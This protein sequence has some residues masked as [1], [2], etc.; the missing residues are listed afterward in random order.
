MAR[1]RRPIDKG[2]L[3]ASMALALG[4]FLVVFALNSATTGRAALG[5]PE[6]I[7]A[8]SPAKN[9]EVLRQTAVVADLAPGYEGKLIIDR[10]EIEVQTV[11]AETNV[12]PNQQVNQDILVTKFDPGSGTL[13]FQPQEGAP[14]EAFATGTHEVKVI[15]WRLADPTQT[16]SYTWQFKVTA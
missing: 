1:T 16:R 7:D 2:L 9:D 6:A 10:R 5:L 8:I 14:I 4:L 3:V 11:A 15:Y 13:T 12:Q